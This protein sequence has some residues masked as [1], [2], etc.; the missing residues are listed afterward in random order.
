[1][2]ENPEYLLKPVYN[3]FAAQEKPYKRYQVMFLHAGKI[4]IDRSPRNYDPTTYLCSITAKDLVKG[5]DQFTLKLVLRRL[6]RARKAGMF[7]P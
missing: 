3:A 5:L 7:R 6:K 2:T 1:M 4:T